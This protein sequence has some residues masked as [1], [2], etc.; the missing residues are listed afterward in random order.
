MIGM[1]IAQ[2]VQLPVGKYALAGEINKAAGVNGAKSK[3]V[4]FIISGSGPTDRDGN[5]VGAKGKNN[6]L[7]YLSEFLNAGGVDTLRVDK[8]GV[9]K[10]LKAGRKEKDLRF[11][12]YVED[13]KLWVSFLKQLGYEEIIIIGHSEGALVAKLAAEHKAVTK[14]VSLAGVGRPASEALKWQLKRSLPE[15]VF[16][17]LFSDRPY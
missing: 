2:E 14:L 4:V 3:K 9:A 11:S 16:D 8:R 15:L 1:L 12:G 10:S 5:T 17:F 6:S 13:A 7:K